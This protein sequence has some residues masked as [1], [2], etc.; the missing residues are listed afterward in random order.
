MA[1][2]LQQ[3]VTKQ[4]ERRPDAIAVWMNHERISYEELEEASNQLASASSG[5]MLCKRFGEIAPIVI[6]DSLHHFQL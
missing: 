2:L 3:L 6:T 4:A 5:R 1:E